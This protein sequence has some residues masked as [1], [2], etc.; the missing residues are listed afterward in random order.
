L[1]NKATSRTG[2]DLWQILVL[3]FVRLGLA[4]DLVFGRRISFGLRS[5]EFG[6]G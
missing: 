1:G 3:G 2:K 4:V 6:I 5:S